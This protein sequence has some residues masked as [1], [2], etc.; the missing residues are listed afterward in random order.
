MNNKKIIQL[1]ISVILGVWVF[2]LVFIISYKTEISKKAQN[3]TTAPLLNYTEATTNPA[4]TTSEEY[5]VPTVT[6]DGNNITAAANVGKPQW[7]IDEEESKKAAQESKKAEEES[8]K[9]SLEAKN[10]T[11][12]KSYVPSGKQEIVNAYISAVNKL[13]NTETFTLIKAN[14]MTYTIDDITGG[15]TIK[16]VAEKVVEQNNPNGTTTYTFKNGLDDAT[17]YS[18]NQ[19]IAPKDIS[20]SLSTDYVKSASAEEGKNGTYTVKIQLGKQVQT[21]DTPAAGYSTVMDVIDMNSLGLTS[22]MTIT[23]LNI[24]YDN[25][26]I[27]AKIDKNGNLLS[28]T[29]YTES[30]GSGEGKLTVIPASMKMHG[31]Y[32]A[33]Y[34]ISY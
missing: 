28:M 21:L 20:A 3:T 4:P 34:T 9:A 33:Q 13:K 11:T 12:T 17:G 15:N 5:S 31:N 24:V 23:S 22:S 6:I 18:P 8:K 14:S 1:L 32:T 26:Y 2:C 29:H 19:I 25:S 10:T 16:Q 30:E 7:L 27:E